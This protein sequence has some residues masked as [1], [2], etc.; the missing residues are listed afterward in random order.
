MTSCRCE[1]GIKTGFY[2]FDE[3]TKLWGRDYIDQGCVLSGRVCG[4]DQGTSQP[5]K[6]SLVKKEQIDLTASCPSYIYLF[7]HQWF[8]LCASSRFHKGLSTQKHDQVH[9]PNLGDISHASIG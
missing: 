6:L 9:V 5:S 4:N 2:S 3:D 7:I 8:D 1:K